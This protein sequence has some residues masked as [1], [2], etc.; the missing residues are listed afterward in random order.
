MNLKTEKSWAED[1][2]KLKEQMEI[3]E[4]DIMD[5]NYK[6][7]GKLKGKMKTIFHKKLNEAAQSK[8]KMQYYIDGKQTWETGKREGYMDKLTR[9]QA[10]I[11]FKARTRMLKMKANYKNGN[12][13][14]TC[15]ACGQTE[16]TQTHIL[17]ECNVINKDQLP[18]TKA[19]IF[20]DCV[21]ALKQT[22]KTIEAKMETLEKTQSTG[23][24]NNGHPCD[25]GT[26]TM[27]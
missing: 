13:N 19:M 2:R 25:Q 22:A 23:P 15:R 16:E 21:N 8:S 6:L 20:S 7:K 17:E 24:Y 10:S 1:N 9:N 14:L 18:I 5:S 27:K 4:E 11:I 26:C 3:T 12:T